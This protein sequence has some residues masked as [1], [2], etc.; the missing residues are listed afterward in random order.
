M[1]KRIMAEY[2]K[3]CPSNENIE[4]EWG[5]I[6]EIINKTSRKCL[7]TTNKAKKKK[8]RLDI[9]NSEIKTVLLL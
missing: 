6:R 1:Y 7:E 3:D 9:W 4:E 5:L 8:K 2:S